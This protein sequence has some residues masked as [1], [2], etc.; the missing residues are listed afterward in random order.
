MAARKFPGTLPSNTVDTAGNAAEAL[1][2][3]YLNKSGLSTVTRNYRCRLGEIDL[4]MRDAQHLVFVEVRL[5]TQQRFGGAAAS[6][7]AHKQRRIVKAAQHYLSNMSS[8]PPCR[9]DVVLL[10]ALDA[11]RIEWI[12][13]AFDA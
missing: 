9:F 4:I 1:A 11:A 8:T 6:I 12:K 7:H 5:R 10:D 2:E 13:N 3:K